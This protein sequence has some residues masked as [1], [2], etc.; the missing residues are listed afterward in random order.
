MVDLLRNDYFS[1]SG[2]WGRNVATRKNGKSNKVD[3]GGPKLLV[4][5][6]R[7]RNIRVR[8]SPLCAPP[9]S[10]HE[11]LLLVAVEVSHGH[12]HYHRYHC[13]CCRRSAGVDA[14]P[15]PSSLLRSLP[16][17]PPSCP[18]PFAFLVGGTW[19]PG[20]IHPST[21]SLSSNPRGPFSPTK[22]LPCPR[23]PLGISLPFPI[24]TPVGF[25]LHF[26]SKP[27]R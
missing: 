17:P 10:P 13:C 16:T 15:P 8:I 2:G 1:I 22:P 20:R 7:C 3:I 25:P 4:D 12:C 19:L 11:V 5:A 6:A 18:L 21:P 26:K 9:F 27:R 23:P 14:T 24:F